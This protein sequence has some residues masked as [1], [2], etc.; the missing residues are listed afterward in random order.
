MELRVFLTESMRGV[1]LAH[2][3]AEMVLSGIDLSELVCSKKSLS[4]VQ[5]GV[6]NLLVDTCSHMKHCMLPGWFTLP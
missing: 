5:Q 1:D 3:D 6:S 4:F 2:V